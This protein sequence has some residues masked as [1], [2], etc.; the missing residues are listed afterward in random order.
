MEQ[1][2][3]DQHGAEIS[4]A[5]TLALAIAIAFIVDRLVLGRAKR[6]AERFAE[7]GVSRGTQTRLQVVR[8]LVFVVIVAIGIALALSQFGSIRRLATGILASSALL[9]LVVG[10]AAR[11]TIAN[12]VAGVMVAI[13]QPIRI[14]DRVTFGDETGRVDDL[15]LTFTYIDTGDGRLMVVPNEQIVSGVLFNHSTGD[16]A[17]PVTASVW[18]PPGSDIETARRA[19]EAAGAAT[20]T[21]A[22]TTPEGVRIEIGTGRD[23]GRTRTGA[24]EAALRERA[25][26]AMRGAGLLEPKE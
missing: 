6:V 19:L 17:A 9:G 12:M 26:A 5:I 11:Q 15:T 7:T 3:W 2:F 23:V 13:T 24:E 4:A 21:V 1:S 14:G 18:L 22:E 10:L 25:L 20:V 8:R 16:Q